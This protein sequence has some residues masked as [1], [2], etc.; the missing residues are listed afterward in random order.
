MLGLFEDL[1]KINVGGEEMSFTLK[2]ISLC[3]PVIVITEDDLGD[4]QALDLGDQA[5][6]DEEGEASR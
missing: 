1:V 2:E 4:E 3:K 5:E 6:G